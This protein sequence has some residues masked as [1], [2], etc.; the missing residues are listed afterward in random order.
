MIMGGNLC[1]Y[2]GER[3]IPNAAKRVIIGNM[4]CSK[5]PLRRKEYHEL[6]GDRAH[7]SNYNEG[8]VTNILTYANPAFLPSI[9]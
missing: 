7:I 2:N 3:G 4:F 9:L 6:V 5:N 8:D 1:V